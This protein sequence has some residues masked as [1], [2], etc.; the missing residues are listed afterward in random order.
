M[1]IHKY[2]I[3]IENIEF[4][5]ICSIY[6]YIHIDGEIGFRLLWVN[7]SNSQPMPPGLI[8]DA[9]GWRQAQ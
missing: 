6:V 3:D 2:R 1:Y 8:H 7:D 9:S 5:R 4:N